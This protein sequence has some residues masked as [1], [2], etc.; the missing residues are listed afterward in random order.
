MGKRIP[1]FRK[2][3][4]SYLSDET[5]RI[6]KHT[7]LSLGAILASAALISA[8]LKEVNAQTAHQHAHLSAPPEPGQTG[9]YAHSSY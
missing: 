9:Y 3:V 5:G 6:T 2:T 7:V 1:Q 8:K 4:S